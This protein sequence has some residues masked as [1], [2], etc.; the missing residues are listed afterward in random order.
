MW[1]AI[2]GGIVKL[3]GGGIAGNKA[4]KAGRRRASVER[5]V[6]RGRIQIIRREE[7]ILRGQTIGGAAGSGVSVDSMSPLALLSE[8]ATQFK[9]EKDI[10]KKVG[11]A[12]AS[13][14]IGDANN[15]ASQYKWSAIGSASASIG[16]AIDRKYGT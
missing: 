14:A 7:R 12:N 11:A 5:E 2:I 10:V 1:G 4:R 3:V 9:R 15:L 16:S 6:T 13:A 8:Q